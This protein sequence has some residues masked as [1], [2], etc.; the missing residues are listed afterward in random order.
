MD[1]QYRTALHE[2]AV[3]GFGSLKQLLEARA[4]C[5]AADLEGRTALYEAA[6][7]NQKLLGRR[8][9]LCPERSGESL[10]FLKGELT[11]SCLYV[12]SQWKV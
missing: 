4:N 11:I 2:A 12:I 9:G 3:S 1:Q 5:H 7:H 10:L 6:C 8:L